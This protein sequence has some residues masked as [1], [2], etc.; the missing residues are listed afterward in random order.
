MNGGASMTD[1]KKTHFK[2]FKSDETEHWW[3]GISQY[4]KPMFGV[5]LIDTNEHTYA[6]EM[7]PSYTAY[8]LYTSHEDPFGDGV[9][10]QQI[11]SADWHTPRVSYFHVHSV[12]E[13]EHDFGEEDLESDYDETVQ[14]MIEHCSCNHYV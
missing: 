13:F 6:C 2:I 8:F 1:E 10:S 5:Y 11:L 9:L 14:D 4:A 3:E 12:K 7:I